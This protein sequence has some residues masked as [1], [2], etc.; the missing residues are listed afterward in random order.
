[1][2]LASVSNKVH[3]GFRI[4]ENIRTIDFIVN[5][6][7]KIHK[8]NAQFQSLQASSIF[9]QQATGQIALVAITGTII[10]ML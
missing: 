2:L 8:D 3:N 7:M 1:M 6:L 4:I 5:I 10:R 9:S